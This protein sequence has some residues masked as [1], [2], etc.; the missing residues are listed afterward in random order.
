[1]SVQFV[2]E[3]PYFG[4]H[5]LRTP[6]G[7]ILPP[8]SRVACYLRSSGVVD[9][10]PPEIANNLVTTLASAL[11]YVRS[12]RGDSI[13]AL[14]GHTENISS[15]ALSGI[16]AGTRLIGI[17]HGTL[18]PTFTANAAGSTLAVNV[19]NVIFDNLKFVAGANGI[20]KLI[21]V[22]GSDFLMHGCELNV[23]AATNEHTLIAVEL[24]TGSSRAKIVNNKFYGIVGEPITDGILVAGVI[25]DFEITHNRMQFASVVAATASLIR[26][27]AV[28]ALRG[29]IARNVLYNTVAA[30]DNCI[31]LAD[32]ASQGICH[33]NYCTVLTN[34]TPATLGISIGATTLWGF[35]NNQCTTNV[36]V[37]GA[38]SPAADS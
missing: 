23:A 13:I 31:V 4:T 26:V 7:V 8:S 37:S 16:V 33:D 34:D 3:A 36:S 35:Y 11:T 14:P 25:T 19:A 18:K 27:G 20:T 32:A 6:H 38:L 24:G 21:N 1:M 9:G 29:L 22:T 17:G 30:S 28:A 10:D 12:G 15:T 5:T 2:Q